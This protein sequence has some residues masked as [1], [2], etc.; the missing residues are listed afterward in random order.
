MFGYEDPFRKKKKKEI[1]ESTFREII[2][3]TIDQEILAKI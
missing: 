3:I 1:R 2:Y